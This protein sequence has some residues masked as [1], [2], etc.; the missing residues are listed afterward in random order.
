MKHVGWI[1]YRALPVVG[2]IQTV[3]GFL[4]VL[5]A[6]CLIGP[7][8]PTDSHTKAMI[9]VAVISVC[10][11]GI[12]FIWAGQKLT[13][14]DGLRFWL[15]LHLQYGD[16]LSIRGVRFAARAVRRQGISWDAEYTARVLLPF[17][18][19]KRVT[20]ITHGQEI[21]W[22]TYRQFIQGRQR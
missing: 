8:V 17:V 9:L 12:T 21:A 1:V 19:G 22:N 14:D 15:W 6:V 20:T 10:A 18:T 16:V 4:I 13:T 2:E 11:F 7:P 3:L 5:A